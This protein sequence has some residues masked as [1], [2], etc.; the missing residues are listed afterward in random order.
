[1]KHGPVQ[2]IFDEHYPTPTNC[3]TACFPTS[4]ATYARSSTRGSSPS[5]SS[6]GATPLH[7][8]GSPHES[9]PSYND[10]TRSRRHRCA[11][12]R[13]QTLPCAHPKVLQ[14]PRNRAEM[15]PCRPRAQTNPRERQIP[16]LIGAKE[17]S[18]MCPTNGYTIAEEEFRARFTRLIEFRRR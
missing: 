15:R 16:G 17:K 8:R 5:S 4:R 9:R 14:P 12:G 7:Y 3:L 11:L 1:M 13:K 10:Y 6:A 2:R 18:I